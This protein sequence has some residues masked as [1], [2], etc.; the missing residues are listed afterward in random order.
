MVRAD[1]PMLT[2][3]TH[4]VHVCVCVCVSVSDVYT[5]VVRADVPMRPPIIDAV[6]VCV[7][8]CMCVCVRRV[9][10][11]GKGRCAHEATNHRNGIHVCVYVCV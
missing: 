1:V 10:S 8:V 5:H 6:H 4:A 9:H 7:C 3:S 11:R 2:V